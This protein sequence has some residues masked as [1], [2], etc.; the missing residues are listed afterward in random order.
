MKLDRRQFV[1]GLASLP[2]LPASASAEAEETLRSIAASKDLFFGAATATSRLMKDRAYA[3]LVGRECDALVA[4]YEMK[5]RWIQSGGPDTFNFRE[6]DWLYQFA[7]RYDMKVRGHTLIWHIAMTDWLK[8]ELEEKPDEQKHIVGY[9]EKVAGRY[10]GRTH[11]WDVANECVAPEDGGKD[12]MRTD[13]PW[14][15]AFGETFIDTAFHA[16]RAT[17]PDA[18]L[19]Y[20]DYGIEMQDGMLQGKWY[21]NRRRAVLDLMERLKTR[22]VPVDALGLQSHLRVFGAKHF[23]QEVL[24][25]FLQKIVDMGYKLMV[26]ELEIRNFPGPDDTPTR[27]ENVAAITKAYLDVLL[28]FKETLGIVTWGLSS[29]YN[30]INPEWEK[31]PPEG[32]DLRNLPFDKE[33][34]KTAMWTSI[35][36]S[37]KSR[38]G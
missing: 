28:D 24:R 2:F 14:Y 32:Y 21:G 1:G 18:V 26:T 22:N 10:K 12:G 19:V 3:D 4:E 27:D 20:N 30:W 23:D 7:R 38:N 35:S 25:D 33:L 37:L 34:Q 9:I 8:Q 31:K 16:A 6:S 11:S 5:Q 15:K 29:R 17:D 36:D 13:S